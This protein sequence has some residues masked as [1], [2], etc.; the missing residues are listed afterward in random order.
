MPRG[1]WSGR[2]MARHLHVLFPGPGMLPPTGKLHA[3]TTLHQRALPRADDDVS[4]EELA[5][6]LERGHARPRRTAFMDIKP[7]EAAEGLTAEIKAWLA[8]RMAELSLPVPKALGGP[9]AAVDPV[10]AAAEAVRA[11][12]AEP[13]A[14]AEATAAEPQPKRPRDDD[15]ADAAATVVEPADAT[16]DATAEEPATKKARP[17]PVLDDDGQGVE[18]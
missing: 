11:S 13:P 6:A 16:A 7:E 18:I 12:K 15:P 9:G 10:F 14:K 1:R 4:E 8:G 3:V 17:A 2:D 5:A